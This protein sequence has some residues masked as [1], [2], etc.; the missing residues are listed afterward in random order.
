MTQYAFSFDVARCSGCLTCVVACQDQND[1][2][3]GETVAFRHVTKHESGTDSEARIAHLSLSCQHCGDAPCVVVCPVGAISRRAEDGVVLVNRNL[4]VGCH[5]CELA[6]PFGAPK[7]PEDGKM[8]KCDLCTVRRDHGLKPACV[9]A[10]PVQA[11]GYGPVE[12]LGEQKAERASIRILQ[13]LVFITD[14]KGE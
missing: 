1:F 2:M 8:A 12:S 6:C 9:R 14:R 5:S 4:C 10:C 7:L 11:L 13:S 3:A